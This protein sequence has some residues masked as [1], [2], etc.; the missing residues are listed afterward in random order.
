MRGERGEYD[1]S[2]KGG[3]EE[4]GRLSLLWQK[5]KVWLNAVI[6]FSLLLISNS[7][8]YTNVFLPS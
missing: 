4:Y 2:M 7:N 1:R 6:K 8:I 5:T 3:Y